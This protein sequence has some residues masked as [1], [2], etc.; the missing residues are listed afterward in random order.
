[1]DC[2]DERAY[3]DNDNDNNNVAASICTLCLYS[4]KQW[5]NFD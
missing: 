4:W 1:M 3:N 5:S 2:D